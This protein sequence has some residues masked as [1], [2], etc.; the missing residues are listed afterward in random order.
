MTN[1]RFVI[2]TCVAAIV[3]GPPGASAAEP[4]KAASAATDWVLKHGRDIPSRLKRT[5]QLRVEGQKL[6]GSTGCNAFTASLVDKADK[7]I[8]VEQVAL[9]RKMCAATLDRVETAFVQAL[10]ESEYLEQKGK[11]LMFLSGKRNALL[12]WTLKKSAARRPVSRKR[13]AHGRSKLRRSTRR[14]RSGGR[15]E[16]WGWRPTVASAG[17]WRQRLF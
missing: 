10:G 14:H 12:V 8:A 9:T 2:F 13:Y 16:C 4:S 6:S 3:L 11:T 7:R 17:R 5:P 15:R 1:L